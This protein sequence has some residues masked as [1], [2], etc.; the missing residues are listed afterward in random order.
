VIDATTMSASSASTPPPST[1]HWQRPQRRQRRRRQEREGTG[2]DLSSSTSSSSDD[3]DG[4]EEDVESFSRLPSISS[5]SYQ[6]RH[7]L[8][9]FAIENEGIMGRISAMKGGETAFDVDLSTQENYRADGDEFYGEFRGIRAGI[10]RDYH[11]EFVFTTGARGGGGWGGVSE[12]GEPGVPRP[13]SRRGGRHF[14]L[15]FV[16]VSVRAVF[17]FVR[18][19]RARGPVRRRI[20]AHSAPHADIQ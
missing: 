18:I 4:H 3:D 19:S 5:S 6:G 8:Y 10:D 12:G 2:H 11:G 9:I 20:G 15:V 13:L 16:F 17:V 14:D 7:S 1:S